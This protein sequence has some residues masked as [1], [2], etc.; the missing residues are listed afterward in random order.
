VKIAQAAHPRR[1]R[2][3]IDDPPQYPGVRAGSSTDR[4]QSMGRDGS[5]WSS[6]HRRPEGATD[7]G[8]AA[9]ARYEWSR[10]RQRTTSVEVPDV[11]TD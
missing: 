4:P 9:H 5:L 10:R 7:F 3:R 8:V 1:Q 6:K 11:G 2:H